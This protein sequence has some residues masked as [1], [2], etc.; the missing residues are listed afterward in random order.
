MLSATRRTQTDGRL[1]AFSDENGVSLEK[2]LNAASL[3][4]YSVIAR[5]G[6]VSTQMRLCYHAPDIVQHAAY[7]LAMMPSSR[8][9]YVTGSPPPGN[10]TSKSNAADKSCTELGASKCLRLWHTEFRAKRDETRRK[11]FKF[12]QE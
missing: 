9:V 7:L 4:L 3:Y 12:L 8:F 2:M 1:K 6:N 11:V 5:P 10:R